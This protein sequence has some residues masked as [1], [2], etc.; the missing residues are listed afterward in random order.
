MSTT[1]PPTY[2]FPLNFRENKF[3]LYIYRRINLSACLRHIN[4]HL[5][6][7]ILYKNKYFTVIFTL[8]FSVT[9]PTIAKFEES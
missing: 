7:Q 3:S 6:S 4:E 8:C 2:K 9:I 5:L 1:T